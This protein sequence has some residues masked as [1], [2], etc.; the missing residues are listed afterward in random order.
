MRRARRRGPLLPPPRAMESQSLYTASPAPAP[1]VE[2][3]SVIE[4]FRDIF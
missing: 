4:D 2:K 1:A 3:T